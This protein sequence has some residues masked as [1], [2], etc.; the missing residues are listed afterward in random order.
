MFLFRVYGEVNKSKKKWKVTWTNPE[1]SFVYPW[2][3]IEGSLAPFLGNRGC[4]RQ[5]CPLWTADQKWLFIHRTF[6]FRKWEKQNCQFCFTFV[7]IFFLLGARNFQS[8]SC[9]NTTGK[10]VEN[11]IPDSA[12]NL[13]SVCI[14]QNLI[15][16]LQTIRQYQKN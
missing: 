15:R 10:G 1:N 3:H 11:A 13:G 9:H 8:K 2:H 12:W 4:N 6:F 5:F 16:I 7:G 14:F